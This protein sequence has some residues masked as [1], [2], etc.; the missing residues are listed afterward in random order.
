MIKLHPDDPEMVRE[1]RE[2][3]PLIS[4]GLRIIRSGD[5]SIPLDHNL[6]YTFIVLHFLRTKDSRF[7]LYIQKNIRKIM[8]KCIACGDTD[9]IRAF[10]ETDD[11]ITKGCIDKYIQRALEC[12]QQEIYDILTAYSLQLKADI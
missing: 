2:I 10:A 12:N 6:K 3:I 1:Y 8:K 7:K 9:V 4:T 5:T 11:F